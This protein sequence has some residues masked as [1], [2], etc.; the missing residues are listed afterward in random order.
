MAQ[1]GPVVTIDY[2]NWRGER[3]ERLIIPIRIHW[4]TSDWHPGVQWLLDAFD[5]EKNGLRT[6]ALKD[7]HSWRPG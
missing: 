7:I 3:S 5:L 4:G 1:A 2:T 6:F